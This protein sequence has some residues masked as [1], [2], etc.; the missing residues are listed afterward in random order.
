[1]N[2]SL[3]S[4]HINL[5]L[6][7][8]SQSSALDYRELPQWWGR[9]THAL[10]YYLIQNM[11]AELAGEIHDNENAPRP[12]TVSTLI[13]KFP[14][15]QLDEN[16]IYNFRLTSLNEEVS[17]IFSQHLQVDG[18]LSANSTIELDY[19]PF[20]VVSSNISAAS[21]YQELATQNIFSSSQPR[22]QLGFNFLS[23][24]AFKSNNK[25]Q[26]LPIA[27]LVFGSLLEKWNL[28]SPLTFPAEAK[29]YAAEC[30][31]VNRFKLETRVVSLKSQSRRIGSV[32]Q[33]SYTSL[34][35][36]KYWLGLLHTLAAFSYFSGIGVG[37]TM[38]LG[39]CTAI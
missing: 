14:H 38:G 12:F 18:K 25:H 37:T 27:E 21:S 3:L 8:T 10:A 11:H 39:Q 31:A 20:L 36:D 17:R 4:I 1:M 5:R 13:G 16:C 15:G 9:A 34:N 6:Q 32:G 7:T 22:R 29:I 19:I 35:Y 26:P 33:C 2:H 23:P 24:T 30:L 28:F